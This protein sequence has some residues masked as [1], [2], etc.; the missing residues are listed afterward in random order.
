M[1]RVLVLSILLCQTSAL[2][3]QTGPPHTVA[4]GDTVRT[5]DGHSSV[6]R[7]GTI[8]SITRDSI[9]IA[10]SGGMETLARG[11][12]I[13]LHLQAA[14]GRMRS[15]KAGA[16]VGILA[17]GVVGLLAGLTTYKSCVGECLIDFGPGMSAFS[18]AL[19]GSAGG[20]VI[21][22]AIGYNM[23]HTRWEPVMLPGGGVGAR[24][25]LK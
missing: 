4:V 25:R 19:I 5:R 6:W 8:H 18:G 20:G 21:G 22:L 11:Q 16:V 14:R 12:A 17:G 2:G 3:G 7:T 15:A 23:W 13:D 10:M 1:L 9:G 24:V